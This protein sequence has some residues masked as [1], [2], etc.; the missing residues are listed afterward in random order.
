MQKDHSNLIRLL[1]AQTRDL[2]RKHRR[3]MSRGRAMSLTGGLEGSRPAVLDLVLESGLVGVK[4][5]VPWAL[6]G[7]LRFKPPRIRLCE[8]MPRHSIP[9][10]KSRRS[11]VTHNPGKSNAKLAVGRDNKGYLQRKEKLYQRLDTLMTPRKASVFGSFSCT[12]G[13]LMATNA[14]IR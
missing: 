5:L 12:T 14:S 11:A 4:G 3:L 8:S 9:S 1:T 6:T 2:A 10:G 13:R 7:L